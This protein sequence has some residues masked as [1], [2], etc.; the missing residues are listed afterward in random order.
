MKLNAPRRMLVF[1]ALSFGAGIFIGARLQ[2]VLFLWGCC[3]LSILLFVLLKSMK[4][5]AWP[6]ELAAMFFLGA[7]ICSYA[8]HPALPPEGKYH[9]RAQVRDRI[10]LREEDG[11]VAVWLKDA[12]LTD[13]TGAEYR[14]SGLYWT[15]W[16]ET[17]DEPLPQQGQT[18]EFTGKVYHPQGK[19]NPFGFDFRMYLLQN[20]M[21]AGATGATALALSPPEQT[22]PRSLIV[23]LRHAIQNR[24][25]LL[26]GKEHHLAT[27]LLIGVTDGMPKEMREGFR[28]AGVAHVL[29][30]SGLHA[31]MIMS[32]V[33]AL[34]DRLSPSPRQTLLAAGSLL[35]VYCL[36]A[37]AEAPLIRAAVLVMYRLAA[38][39]VRRRPD[40][41]TGLAIGFIIILLIQPLE[42]FSAGFQMSFGAMLGIIMLG[43]RLH[44]F[45]IKMPDGWRK[46]LLQTY[47]ISLCAVMGTALP[48]IYCYNYLSVVGLFIN[49]LVCLMTECLLMLFIALLLISVISLPL[50][51]VLGGWLALASRWIVQ[52]VEN[53]GALPF[54]SIAVPDP[55]WYLALA[56]VVC[57]LLCTRYTI[58]PMRKR[59]L[60]GAAL[61]T[62]CCV[63][64]GLTVCRDVRYIQ[65]DVGNADAAVIADGHATIVI[66]TGEY[67]GDLADYL[68]SSGR[69]ADHLVLT[70]L[71]ADHALGLQHLLND[72]VKIGCIYLSTEAKV[73]QSSWR[74]LALLEEAEAQGIPVRLVSAGDMI[75]TERV[76]MQILWPEEGGAHA[77][78]DANDS[79]MA[80]RIDLDGVSMLHMS[81]LSGTYELYAA[82]P[83][84]IVRVAHHGGAGSTGDRF[85]QRVQPACALISGDKPSE[86]TL[87]RLANAGAMVYDTGAYGALTITV[88]GGNYMVQGYKQ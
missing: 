28:Q 68:L 42:L 16:P 22:G 44:S 77:I 53:A 33:I 19:T 46:R 82:Q 81:D 25:A 75:A 87:K 15:Y 11:R 34:L 65:L 85:L 71:H 86:K 73:P 14:L 32:V 58:L 41:L 2:T 13:E 83:A 60:T 61:L 3:A 30:V 36:L 72:G 62:I 1:W 74:V 50:A 12:Q 20:G 48:V 21:P 40:L 64:M 4:R 55:P 38:R 26:L 18:A 63:A 59:L 7:A 80:L 23:R 37:G 39:C 54:S 69:N 29:S 78:A 10:T 88:R 84:D 49:P 51:Q 6:V 45:L 35:A 79:A 52:G 17:P 27:A 66:D 67:G 76:C 8:A 56:L 9:I 70:H 57:L 43:D 47:G 31:M 5:A 24:F